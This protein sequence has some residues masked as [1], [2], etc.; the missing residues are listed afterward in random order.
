MDEF[1]KGVLNIIKLDLDNSRSDINKYD[2]LR[3]FF[4]R[5]YDNKMRLNGLE[6]RYEHTNFK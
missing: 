5:Y 2:W 3:D 1:T 6:T 4:I